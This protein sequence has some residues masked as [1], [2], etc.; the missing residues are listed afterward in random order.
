MDPIAEITIKG[1]TSIYKLD[2]ESKLYSTVVKQLM[3]YT[4]TQDN[5]DLPLSL[6][7]MLLLPKKMKNKIAKIF[8]NESARIVY[9]FNESWTFV[10]ASLQFLDSGWYFNGEK[11]KD[12]EG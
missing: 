2:I 1:K 11:I 12:Y 4:M 8:L 10:L 6:P 9:H 3:T 7:L 5:N